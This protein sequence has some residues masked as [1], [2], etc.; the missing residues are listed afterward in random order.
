MNQTER[1]GGFRTIS[2]LLILCLLLSLCACGS[3]KEGNPAKTP[4]AGSNP[5]EP[6]V[7]VTEIP[8]TDSG[9]R[10]FVKQRV[11]DSGTSSIAVCNGSLYAARN[12]ALF[13]LDGDSMTQ[14]Y[15][16]AADEIMAFDVSDEGF[17]CLSKKYTETG[18]V[19]F[20]EQ[21]V[22]DGSLLFS[23]EITALPG[24][25]SEW[26]VPQDIKTF[27][28]LVYLRC[29]YAIAIFSQNEN[30]FSD[31]YRTDNIFV[32][33]VVKNSEGVAIFTMIDDSYALKHIDHDAEIE[34]PMTAIDVF[35]APG[36]NCFYY[37]T[38]Q[39]LYRLLPDADSET[40]V[41][42]SESAIANTWLINAAPFRDGFALLDEWEVYLL[43]PGEAQQ[44][45]VITMA[46]TAHINTI[47]RYITEFN[48]S[49]DSVYVE[50]EDLYS[51][52]GSRDNAVTALNTRL[53]AGEGPDLIYSPGGTLGT[54]GTRGFLCDLYDF[55]DADADLNREDFVGLSA[56]E[57]DGSLF[58]ACHSF[59][60]YTYV[61][62]TSVFGE[63]NGWTF[64][65]YFEMEAQRD[66]SRPVVYNI[67]KENF[68]ENSLRAYLPTA[69]DWSQGTCNFDCEE[70]IE[71]LQAASRVQEA[72][73]GMDEDYIG[74]MPGELLA[75]DVCLLFAMPFTQ[76]NE[77]IDE[78]QAANQDLTFIGWPSPDGHNTS[79][80]SPLDCLGIS[81]LSPNQAAA[82]SF[83]K[84]LISDPEVQEN[85]RW[86]FP[87][88]RAAVEAK[89]DELL[90][91]FSEL[92]GKE[93]VINEDGSFYAD[94]ELYT[95]FA[96]DPTP[97]M[98]EK[99]AQKIWTLLDSLETNTVSDSVVQNIVQ[100]EA[101]AFLAGDKTAEET[102]RLIQSRVQLY[103]GE[104]MR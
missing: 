96:Y 70:F 13:T 2:A 48:Q 49:S 60:A 47:S 14:L 9:R 78:E 61:G 89:V 28:G 37:E 19:L 34:L 46:T 92:E 103:V 51:E 44:K 20:L 80:L 104:Q 63:R 52:Y 22:P 16:S 38:D 93:I 74:G 50:I 82:W 84:Y 57:T 66:S 69:I 85:V 75:S 45:R 90:H 67:S 5:A 4:E 18:D 41:I 6:G 98:T 65:E 32:V 73:P 31:V 101:A 33:K 55:I 21:V 43:Q 8:E 35:D 76:I 81:A 3:G 53:I 72:Y 87:V 23:E 17:F 59:M 56:L 71:L 94:G 95:E 88:L 11:D 79:A 58:Y 30:S 36:E 97:N 91:P 10:S 15:S 68:L 83:L 29:T 54:Y 86:G 64:D 24:Y 25:D 1:R 62:L 102:A 99:Q 12:N 7:S 100:E 39:G 77:F 26:G 27:D 40:V 42:W